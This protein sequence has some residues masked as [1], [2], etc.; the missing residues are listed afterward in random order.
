MA[1]A[2]P[3]EDEIVVFVLFQE[4]YSFI[5]VIVE[6]TEYQVVQ[7]AVKSVSKEGTHWLTAPCSRQSGTM[8]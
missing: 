6:S 2:R 4:D 5:S 8:W 3:S 7:K 1:T